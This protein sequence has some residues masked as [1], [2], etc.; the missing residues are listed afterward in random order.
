MKNACRSRN[1]VVGPSAGFTLVELMVVVAIVGI[2][3]AIA[4]PSYQQ[5]VLKSR[6][7]EAQSY[8]HQ[9]ALKQEQYWARHQKYAET[10]T[11]LAE[12][13]VVN[14][15]EYYVFDVVAGSNPA[16]SYTLK[17]DA[18]GSQLRDESQCLSLTMDQS[19]SKNGG[20]MS[21]WSK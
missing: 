7:A 4:I 3:A 13:G 19:G 5:Y 6:R 16:S 17:A 15:T 18:Q 14:D 8:L 2:L 12:T 10:K 11:E 9:L 21:C 20:D 1:G